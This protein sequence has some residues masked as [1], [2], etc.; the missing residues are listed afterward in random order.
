[1]KNLNAQWIEKEIPY[2]GSELKSHF[3][4]DQFDL[5]G[6]SLVA[7]RGPCRVDLSQMVDL[8]D[9]KR[10]SPIFSESMLHFL[11]EFYGIS[12]E[13]TVLYQRLLMALM[14]DEL[15]NQIASLKIFRQGDD[16]YD[17]NYKL[18]VSIAT[19]S[20]VSTLIHAG[21]NI[22][23]Q[24]TPVPTRGLDDY[25]IPAIPFAQK[26]LKRFEEEFSG[27]SK[28]VAKVRGVS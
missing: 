13:T 20:P 28:A 14:L 10:Q 3:I 7:F 27:T 1:M 11:G 4:Y 6:D 15:R 18:S 12:L 21:I 2:T 23:S 19:V 8:E 16:L 9:V 22:S 17:E 25:K 24:N 26:I 5:L